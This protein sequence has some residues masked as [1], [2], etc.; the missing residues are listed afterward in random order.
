VSVRWEGL[1]EWGQH[2]RLA[3]DQLGGA[4]LAVSSVSVSR[5]NLDALA[6]VA[7]VLGIHVF[8]VSDLFHDPEATGGGR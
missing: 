1:A 5:S 6:A 3:Q 4:R 2:F 7:K 8:H